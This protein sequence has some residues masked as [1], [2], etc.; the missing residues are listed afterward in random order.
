ME[1]IPYSDFAK[2]EMRV[3]RILAV[4][5]FPEAR[6]PAFKLT[7]DFGPHGV[8]RS[9]AQVTNYS[10][11]ELLNRLVV[12]VTNF[13]PKRVGKFQSE[14]LVLGAINADDTVILIKPDDGAELGAPIA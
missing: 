11:E 1:T 6:K 10:K 5:D 4:E 13:A 2:V 9:S 14:V 7:I 8:R 12:A 3:G